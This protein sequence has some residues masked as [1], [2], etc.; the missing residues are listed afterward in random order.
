MACLQS[1]LARHRAEM[2]RAQAQMMRAQAVQ[3]RDSR[4]FEGLGS[5]FVVDVPEMPQASDDH[6]F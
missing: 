4:G 6:S 2:V 5:N 1:T 3:A